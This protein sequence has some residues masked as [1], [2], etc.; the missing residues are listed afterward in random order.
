MEPF[1][2]HLH[3]NIT[4][5]SHSLFTTSLPGNSLPLT[6]ELS[7]IVHYKRVSFHL[8]W[9]C[10]WGHA[11]FHIFLPHLCW[12]HVCCSMCSTHW[13]PCNVT[14]VF[15]M[16]QPS[17]GAFKIHAH[18]QDYFVILRF[19]SLSTNCK[20]VLSSMAKLLKH[21]VFHCHVL[22]HIFYC[23]SECCILVKPAVSQKPDILNMLIEWRVAFHKPWLFHF[24]LLPLF[25]HVSCLCV[26]SSFHSYLPHCM[27]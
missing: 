10:P 1:C 26:Y 25:P 17:T 13:M 19:H 5:L 6:L 4:R 7:L 16:L 14:S 24:Y 9:K 23:V 27:E 20:P 18:F 2:Y 15:E 22:C 21:P 3:C 11:G 8:H 12:I